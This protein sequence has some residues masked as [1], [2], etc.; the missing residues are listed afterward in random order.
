M[1]ISQSSGGG[2][3]P[4]GTIILPSLPCEF[5]QVTEGKRPPRD[6]LPQMLLVS[7]INF[8]TPLQQHFHSLSANNFANGLYFLYWL[9]R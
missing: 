6:L 2:Q 8:H 9:R 4:S 5:T 7:T 3:S 1:E